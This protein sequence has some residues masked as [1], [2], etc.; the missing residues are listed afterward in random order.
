MEYKDDEFLNDFDDQAEQTR[1]D[2]Y[3]DDQL[4]NTRP[5]AYRVDDEDGVEQKDLERSFLFGHAEM[6]PVREGKPMGG[7]SFGKNNVTPAADDKN[8]P[9]QNA[10]YSNAYFKRTEPAQ[11]HPENSNFTPD[12][13]NEYIEGTV[14]SDGIQQVGA[15]GPI[16]IPGRREFKGEQ[17]D[18]RYH[19]ET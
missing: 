17:G 11:E 13:N 10:G 12:G 15:A 8:N 19:I 2:V 6:K 3:P 14:D 5:N 9:S 7:E 18:G 1:P 16:D 4:K